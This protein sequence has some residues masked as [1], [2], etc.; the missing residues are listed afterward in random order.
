MKIIPIKVHVFIFY[1]YSAKW[2]VLLEYG[3]EWNLYNCFKAKLDS[4]DDNILAISSIQWY[5]GE[6]VKETESST[7]CQ[8]NI[9]AG[10]IQINQNGMSI[11]WGHSFLYFI[12]SCIQT[13]A[14]KKHFF[15][16]TGLNTYPVSK[17][18]TTAKL[19]Y[20]L[21]DKILLYCEIYVCT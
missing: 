6:Q 2:V 17:T 20:I 5:V 8:G 13:Y 1:I 10:C 16:D 12:L 3:S 11:L 15:T 19:M 18:M 21:S 14:L 4:K 7:G 9:H